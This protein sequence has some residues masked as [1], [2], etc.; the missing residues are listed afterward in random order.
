MHSPCDEKQSNALVYATGKY[1]EDSSPTPTKTLPFFREILN[2]L[3]LPFLISTDS[4]SEL[5]QMVY[6]EGQKRTW[7]QECIYLVWGGLL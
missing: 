7:W 2:W 3:F 5:M 1:S 4:T 6:R